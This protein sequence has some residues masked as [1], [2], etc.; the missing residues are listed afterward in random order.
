VGIVAGADMPFNV[1][2]SDVSTLGRTQTPTSMESAPA[3]FVRSK[4]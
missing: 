4:N 2:G 3:P 1:C